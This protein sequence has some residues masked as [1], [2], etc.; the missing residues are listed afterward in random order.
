MSPRTKL[1]PVPDPEP[2]Q[3]Q[4]VRVYLDPDNP[5]AGWTEIRPELTGKELRA[6]LRADEDFGAVLDVIASRTVAHSFDGDILDQEMP[7]LTRV[8][9]SWRK[10]D[11][12]RALDPN[13]A[14]S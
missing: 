5:A 10:K 7:V 2:E 3:P 6:L 11:S 8:L 4:T 14:S 13:S 1:E 12:E 9:H